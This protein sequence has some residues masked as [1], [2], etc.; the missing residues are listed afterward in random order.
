MPIFDLAYFCFKTSNHIVTEFINICIIT[1]CRFKFF[2]RNTNLQNFTFTWA[3][4]LSKFG[5][6]SYWH[7]SINLLNY[8]CLIPLRDEMSER[9]RVLVKTLLDNPQVCD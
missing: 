8:F 1:L 3:F 7:F 2:L 6:R 9:I 4:H 5:Q